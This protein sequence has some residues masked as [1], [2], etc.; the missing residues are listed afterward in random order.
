MDLGKVRWRFDRT[1]LLAVEHLARRAAE[2]AAWR[3]IA[4]SRRVTASAVRPASREGA[5]PQTK[6]RDAAGGEAHLGAARWVGA[7]VI[8]RQL[9]STVDR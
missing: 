7:G 9:V 2:P 8:R 1:L 3:N 6:T 5:V 4:R